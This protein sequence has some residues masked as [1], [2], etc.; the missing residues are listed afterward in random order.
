M[1]KI[2]STAR[3]TQRLSGSSTQLN[4]DALS[5]RVRSKRLFDGALE[6]S[7]FSEFAFQIRARLSYL[8]QKVLLIA[9]LIIFLADREIRELQR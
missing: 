5:R 7:A 6:V 2:L 9:G 8:A 4:K 3:I 1:R